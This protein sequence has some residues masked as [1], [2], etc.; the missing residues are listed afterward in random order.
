MLTQRDIDLINDA[1]REEADV[2]QRRAAA[3]L[4]GESAFGPDFVDDTM[5][6]VIAARQ[7]RRIGMLWRY[8]AAAVVVALVGLTGML[9]TRSPGT[10][11]EIA[12][13]N[14]A[15]VDNRSVTLPDGTTVLVAPGSELTMADD[16]ADNRTV[17]L[18]GEAYF[19]VTSDG[20]RFVVELE[21]GSVVVTG[22]RFNARS[23]PGELPFSEVVLVEGS[24]EIHSTGRDA[25]A[26][27]AGQTVRF[28]ADE[29]AAPEPADLAAALAW[30]S[31]AFGF[32]DVSLG[33]AFAEIG[34]RFGVDIKLAEGVDP[35]RRVTY[36]APRTGPLGD[37]LSDL[38]HALNLN[39]RST[40]LGYEIRSND[41]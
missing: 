38:C 16:F 34:R 31:G 5:A 29:V 22:T 2:T 28:Q 37:V 10:E 1:L 41:T 30:H 23:W 12:G 11:L 3:A 39:F 18:T 32:R 36:L 26:I 19:D 13:L 7:G 15:G 24:V 27:E 20:S 8:A 9:L 35:D 4:A 17:R 21:H 33:F 40:R 6:A 14:V 25:V